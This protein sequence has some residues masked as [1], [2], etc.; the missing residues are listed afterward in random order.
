[1]KATALC[2]LGTLSTLA[3]AM[4]MPAYAEEK[5]EERH[6][7][8][9][10]ID[11]KDMSIPEAASHA[12]DKAM[13]ALD[14]ALS[15]KELATVNAEE[16]R[17]SIRKA[18]DEANA[19]GVVINRRSA[20]DAVEKNNPYSAR[21]V[22]EFKQSLA[23]GTVIQRQ[24]T[25]LLARDREGRLRQELRQADGSARVFIND[26]VDKAAYIIDPQKKTACRADFN[27]RAINDCYSQ[28]K[29]D[30]KPLGF[31]LNANS[32]NG[33]GMMSARDDIAVEVSPRAQIIDLTRKAYVH[34]DGRTVEAPVPPTPPM[35][36]LPPLAGMRSGDSGGN[37]QVSREKKT[38]QSYEG[39]QVD[40]DRTVE[41]IAAGAIGNSKPIESIVER[42]YSPELKM[43]VFS[44]RSDPRNGESIYRMVDIKRSEPDA[45]LFRVPTGYNISE[46]KK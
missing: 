31:M 36:P 39:L 3:A 2:T 22:R 33:L 12:I 45:S 35:P 32:R 4:A 28:I 30:W 17:E 29:G 1:M 40:T 38:Q 20:S 46:G 41:T 27:E 16:I 14:S 13:A 23:D 18:I 26:P 11:G 9:I 37:A 5:K 7:I 6:S 24:S 44:R 43:T 19:H 8:V 10:K 34:R 25:R 42:Y 15:S 21:E